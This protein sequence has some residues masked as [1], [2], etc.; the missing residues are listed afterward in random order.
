[1]DVAALRADFPL[2]QETVQGQP[3]IYL[4][5]AA[6]TQRPRQVLETLLTFYTRYNANIHRSPHTLGQIATD[7][8]EQAHANVARFIGAR[9]K[10]EI[11]FTRNTTEALNL[12]AVTLLRPASGALQLRPGDEVLVTALE[13][14]SNLVP[15]QSLCAEA[16]LTLR[17][18][19]IQADGALDLARFTA[20]LN[21][22]TR[23]VCCTYVSNVHGGINPIADLA[24]LAHQ[25]GALLV[26][27]AAQAVP[28]L[29]VDVTALDCDFLAFSGHKLL[30]PFGSGVLYGRE[31][32]LAQLAPFLYGGGMV[33][34]VTATQATWRALPGKFEAGTPDVATAIALGGA[35]DWTRDVYLTGAVDYLTAIGFAAIHAHTQSLTQQLLAGLAALPE[36]Q[37]LGPP[38]AVPRGPLVAFTVGDANA[39]W[40]AQLLNGDG[41][42]VRAGGHCAYPLMQAL[43]I[44]GAVR[45]SPYLYN[46]EA[47]IA[48][49]LNVLEDIIRFR[50]L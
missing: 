18:A 46:T 20:L 12:L 21:A 31:A 32:L 41:I 47:E 24:R 26:V 49:F 29:P 37:V 17:V 33:E 45:V 5:N 39:H 6:T 23:L 36:V 14:H 28:H 25:A 48:R 50:L 11:V 8:Y 7:L 42:A 19:D 9:S 30:A 38:A 44:P 22:R 16:G 34:Q 40:I 2:L 43:G 10:R 15:W 27:D 35:R 3:L 4:D 1:M 13:H